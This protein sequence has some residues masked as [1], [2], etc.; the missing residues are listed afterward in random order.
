MEQCNMKKY[1]YTKSNL[2]QKYQILTERYFQEITK[3]MIHPEHWDEALNHPKL[4]CFKEDGTLK[5]E[6]MNAFQSSPMEQV[7]ETSEGPGLVAG[8]EDSM[9]G[10]AGVNAMGGLE[11]G[12]HHQQL[13]MQHLHNLEECSGNW[14]DSGHPDAALFHEAVQHL[15]EYMQECSY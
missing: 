6:C 3:E 4:H 12:K 8:G 13:I 14:A 15:K 5:Q 1:N 9:A 11:E 2:G 7:P 10:Y